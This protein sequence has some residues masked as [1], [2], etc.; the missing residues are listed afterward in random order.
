MKSII[1]SGLGKAYKQYPTRWSRL[2]EW[3]T[4]GRRQFHDLHWV[5]RDVSFTADA[6]EAVGIIGINGAGKSTLLKM[7]AGTAQAT[8]GDVRTS[9]RVAAML[10]LGLGLVPD[11]IGRQN[12]RMAGQ[13]LGLSP[14]EIDS[15]MPEIE[16][17][18][19]IGEYFDQAVRIY[20]SGMQARVAFSVA[21]SIRPDILIVDEALSVGDMAFQAKCMQRMN[22]LLSSGTTILFVSHSLNLVRQ[23]CNK[24][25]YISSGGVKAWGDSDSVCDLYQ[26]DLVGSYPVANN[27]IATTF[28]ETKHFDCDRDPELRKYSVAGA[29]GGTLGLEF[30]KLRIVDEAGQTISVCKPQ[31]IIYIQASILANEDVVEGAA[32]GLLFADKSGYPIM[33][34]N[35]NYYDKYLPSLVSGNVVL[36]EWKVKLPFY[37][38]EFRCDIGIKPD[39]FSEIFYDRV[40][41]V[42]TLTVIPELGLLK[43]NF[44]GYFLADAEV[45]VKVLK[46]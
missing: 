8:A 23:F 44:G 34:C 12:A 35:A 36:I 31:Q 21:T 30:L 13:L 11:F 6:G 5:L 25:L 1:V 32:V 41:C 16:K 45:N 43:K 22:N 28:G 20:S 18:S 2:R 9:G 37:S 40:F 3:V 27:P 46:K 39:E 4:P 24:A 19:D 33:A 38:G 17:F 15:L 10:E 14:S 42:A 7:I 29:A 26:N